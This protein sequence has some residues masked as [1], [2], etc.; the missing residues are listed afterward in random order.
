MLLKISQSMLYN[1]NRFL[2]HTKAMLMFCYLYGCATPSQNFQQKAHEAGFSAVVLKTAQF[3]HKLYLAKNLQASKTLHVYL[4]G[5]GT[6]W[7]RNRWIAYDPTARNPMILALMKQD[8]TPSVLLGRPCYYGLNESSRCDNKFWTSHRYS[9]AVVDSMSQT[10]NDWLKNYDFDDVVLIGYSGGGS[11]AVLM[12]DKIRHVKTIMT[13]AA[14][15]DLQAWSEFH[16][17]TTLKESLNPIEQNPLTESIKQIHIAGKKDR[18]V[19]S[20]V[21]KSYAQKQQNAIYYELVDQD[22]ACCWQSEW[23]SL[24]G[25]LE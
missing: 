11:L 19:P 16:G 20:F 2:L 17:Y 15:L 14:N 6:P 1:T 3:Q 22:H 21:I 23:K 5:D 12:A 13:V 4:D 18:V 9:K 25:L 8:A 24:L 10:L 7:E